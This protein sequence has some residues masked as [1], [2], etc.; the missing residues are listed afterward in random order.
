MLFNGLK[1]SCFY[2]ST[3]LKPHRRAEIAHQRGG[4]ASSRRFLLTRPPPPQGRAVQVGQ[5]VLKSCSFGETTETIP[6]PTLGPSDE[7]LDGRL[8]GHCTLVSIFPLC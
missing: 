5:G 7:G 8:V 3:L 4:P 6:F 2:I 1:S